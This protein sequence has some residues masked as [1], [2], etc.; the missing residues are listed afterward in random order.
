MLVLS[1]GDN[2]IGM[3][4]KKK[5]DESILSEM[6]DRMHGDSITL[7]VTPKEALK[8]AFAGDKCTF[9]IVFRSTVDTKIEE[10]S[11][12]GYKNLLGTPIK[13]KPKVDVYRG[14]KLAK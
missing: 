10:V 6:S 9:N 13:P 7:A 2:I 14:V 4:D 12:I 11:A 1:V 8:I 3:L 5:K